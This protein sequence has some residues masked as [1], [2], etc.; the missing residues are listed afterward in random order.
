MTE[1]IMPYNEKGK[2]AYRFNDALR[3]LGKIEEE[4]NHT[5]LNI[6]VGDI[7]YAYQADPVKAIRW[8]CE[9]TEVERK[10]SEIDDRIYSGSGEIY[11]GPFIELK[12]LYEYR[13]YQR[14][15]LDCLREKGYR[16]NMQGAWRISRLPELAEYIQ[17]TDTDL[18][19]DGESVKINKK[20][21]LQKLRKLAEKDV[22]KNPKAENIDAKRYRRSPYIAAYVKRRAKGCCELCKKAA[23]FRDGDGEPYLETHHVVWLSKGGED[24]MDNAAALCPNCHRKMHIVQCPEDILYLKKLL[25]DYR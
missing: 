23:P 16:G 11:G 6:E 2:N 13:N 20:I 12:A 15:S 18:R 7:I 1:W 9:V 21:S 5:L 3:D 24:S 10:I 22:E 4:Q 17:K 14:L 25:K 19:C 8:K